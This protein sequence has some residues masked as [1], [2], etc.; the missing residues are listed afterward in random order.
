MAFKNSAGNNSISFNA[1]TP[2]NWLSVDAGL[3]LN[4]SKET[5][6]SFNL[7]VDSSLT[8]AYSGVFGQIG[9]QVAF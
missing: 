9:L 5:Q 1:Q 4:L 8:G 7:G 6:L 2:T 3:N